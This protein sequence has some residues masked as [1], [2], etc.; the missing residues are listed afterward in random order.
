MIQW[1][2]KQSHYQK[3]GHAPRRVSILQGFIGSDLVLPLITRFHFPEDLWA[4]LNT[5]L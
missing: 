2:Y 5:S 1:G 3:F 4:L